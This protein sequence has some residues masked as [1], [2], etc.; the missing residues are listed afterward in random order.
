MAFLWAGV[1]FRYPL[2]PEL[3]IRTLVH[4]ILALNGETQ[5]RY[6]EDGSEILRE[7]HLRCINTNNGINYQPQLVN[8]GFQ[9]STVCHG[10]ESRAQCKFLPWGLLRGYITNHCPFINPVRRPYLTKRD[11]IREVPLIPC[12]LK[13]MKTLKGKLQLSLRISGT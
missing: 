5:Q 2:D 6:W 13:G 12:G 9:A 7:N 4:G 8:A 10:N 1:F 3:I 11:G